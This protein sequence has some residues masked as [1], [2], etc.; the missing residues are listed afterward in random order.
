MKTRLCL[1]FLMLAFAA[2]VSGADESAFAKANQAYAESRF[3]EAAA[4]YESL[5][6]SGNW[7]ANL[8]YDLGNA[9][10]RLGDFGQ[11]ILNYERALALDPRHPEADANLRLARDEARALELRRDWM[12]RYASIGTA[13]QYTIAA[14]IAFWFAMFLTAHAILGRRRSAGRIALIALSLIVCALSII[15]IVALENG[16]RGQALAVV[17]GQ[18]VEAR[19]ATADNA[20]SMLVLPAGSEI[21]IVS[22][23]GDWI[24]VALPNDQRGWIPADAAQRVR[25]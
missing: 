21:K 1:F 6:A 20:K 5:I 17:T 12:E 11:A 15:A 25:M 10:Y 19:F 18:G 3:D 2:A 4:G 24:Y 23:R 9:R 14:A 8:F 22:E 7:N 13:K 16:A